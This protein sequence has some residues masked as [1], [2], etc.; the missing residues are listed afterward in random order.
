VADTGLPVHV[1]IIGVPS[2][3]ASG[4]TEPWRG[5]AR[6]AAAQ[7]ASRFGAQVVVEYL[8]L[9]SAEA[10]ALVERVE[11]NVPLVFVGDELFSAGSKVL[12]PAIRE[13][14]EGMGIKAIESQRHLPQRSK[15]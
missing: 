2:A 7:L 5:V 15:G 10:L 12:I 11:G 9:F 3:C 1:R 14:L 13:R 4:A 8:D 6:L